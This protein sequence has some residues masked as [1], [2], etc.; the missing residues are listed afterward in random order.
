MNTPAIPQDLYRLA[1]AKG[2]YMS[3]AG[4]TGPFGY[5]K[6]ILSKGG[7]RH[8]F[9]DGC[10]GIAQKAAREFLSKQ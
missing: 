7:K 2:F 5:Y 8:E 4:D 1:E 10:I 6:V 9:K 3:E